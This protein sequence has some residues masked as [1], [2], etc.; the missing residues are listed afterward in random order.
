MSPTVS[1]TA[2]GI[3]RQVQIATSALSH[4][5][6][7]IEQAKQRIQELKKVKSHT[8]AIDQ[9]VRQAK[10][11]FASALTDLGTHLTALDAATQEEGPAIAFLRT[12]HKQLAD[13][14]AS[15]GIKVQKLE[16]DVGHNGSKSK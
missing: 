14:A 4:N 6:E 5:Q 13:I 1:T 12:Q 2:T 8:A 11:E 10:V 9:I 7:D 15:M 16:I 3:K